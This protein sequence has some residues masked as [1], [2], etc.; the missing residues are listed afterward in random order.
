[1]SSI[2]YPKRT[3]LVP[4][5]RPHPQ[6]THYKVSIGEEEWN[7]TLHTVIKVQIM[8]N[9]KVS[10]RI[11]PSFPYNTDDAQRVFQAIKDIEAD[12]KKRPEIKVIPALP[13]KDIPKKIFAMLLS[14]VPAGQITRWEDIEAFLCN[15]YGVKSVEPD[16]YDVWPDYD[17]E[18]NVIPYWRV[19]GSYG[20]LFTRSSKL[21]L[22][23]QERALTQEGFIIEPCGARN[24]S[25]RV[26]DYRKYLFD[27]YK[28]EIRLDGLD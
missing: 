10:G 6:N 14:Q 7:G 20:Y 17:E 9:G 24:K 1:M 5:S 25:K 12:Y 16:S 3:I 2:F 11:S 21:T 19:V 8:N 13:H 28:S 15:K 22:E 26:K 18:G 23:Q 4:A 27:Y